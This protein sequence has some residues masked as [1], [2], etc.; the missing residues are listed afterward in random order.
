[1]WR[2]VRLLIL[3][4]APRRHSRAAD[5]AAVCPYPVIRPINCPLPDAVDRRLDY[6]PG[7]ALVK[8]RTA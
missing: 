3:V 5:E 8:F 6:V 7:E 1:M 2:S 4:G